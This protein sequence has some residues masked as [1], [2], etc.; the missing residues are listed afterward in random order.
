MCIDVITSSPLIYPLKNGTW[1]FSAQASQVSSTH[2]SA[3]NDHPPVIATIVRLF[4]YRRPSTIGRFVVSVIVDAVN[5]VLQGWSRPHISHEVV[6]SCITKPSIANCDAS[7]AI[8]G[9]LLIRCVSASTNHC[10]PNM[11]ARLLS[12]AMRCK[13][14]SE[15]LV[16]TLPAL[17]CRSILDVSGANIPDSSAVALAAHC[18][19]LVA[20]SLTMTNDKQV[21]IGLADHR[22]AFI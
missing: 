6:E 13:S 16:C 7:A 22:L 18:R 17:R 15:S 11:K 10:S 3:V 4:C 2:R 5:R 1:I 20:F 19:L 14:L 8:I 9:I 21:A 12:F